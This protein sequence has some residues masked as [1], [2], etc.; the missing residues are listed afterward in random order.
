VRAYEVNARDRVN[1]IVFFAS[2]Q[3]LEWESKIC[4]VFPCETQAGW[5][6][7]FKTHAA[8]EDLNAGGQV[9]T[10]DYNPLSVWGIP[11]YQTYRNRV[12]QFFGKNVMSDL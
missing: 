8:D 1:N 4:R 5:I 2:M 7:Q 10:D 9:L 12:M 11:I 3:P 6:E